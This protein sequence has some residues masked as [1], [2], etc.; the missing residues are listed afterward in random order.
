MPGAFLVGCASQ[1]TEVWE[2]MVALDPRKAAIVEGG[3]P[4]V[5]DCD[6]G[7]DAG[8]AEIIE[9]TPQRIVVRTSAEQPALLVQTDSYY[10][11]WQATID[12]VPAA[13]LR[14]DLLFRGVAVPAG[15]HTVELTYRPKKVL[16]ALWIAPLALLSLLGL[17]VF[18][19]PEPR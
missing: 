19:R 14:A 17:C 12:G 11:G 15:E 7:E 10:P 13:L 3:D 6:D 2:A 4:G 1:P 8:E 18:Q 9:E 16:A 5:P